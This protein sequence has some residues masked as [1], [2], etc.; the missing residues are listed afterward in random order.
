MQPLEGVAMS[1]RLTE[2]AQLP[3]CAIR[4]VP[5]GEPSIGFTRRR[6]RQRIARHRVHVAD[7]GTR[8]HGGTQCGGSGRLDGLI[9]EALPILRTAA[10]HPPAEVIAQV[11][12]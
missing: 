1:L 8:G 12:S 6:W 10:T 5:D 4:P 3:P 11:G 9:A 7:A 2:V